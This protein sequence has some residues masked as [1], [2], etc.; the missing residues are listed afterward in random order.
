VKARLR[1]LLRRVEREVSRGDGP[2]RDLRVG[3]SEVVSTAAA[4]GGISFDKLADRTRQRR[5][6]CEPNA[7]SL[8]PPIRTRRVL[9]G[10]PSLAMADEDADVIGGAKCLA[11]PDE[12]AA[13]PTEST[14]SAGERRDVLRARSCVD[15]RA[16]VRARTVDWVESD[17]YVHSPSSGEL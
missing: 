12:R 9:A 6:S 5:C 1:I 15:Q 3:R 13:G 2:G 4:P 11:E 7:C 14:P 8:D 16:R 10:C 17:G